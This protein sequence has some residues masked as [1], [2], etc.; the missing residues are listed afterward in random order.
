MFGIYDSL[1]EFENPKPVLDSEDLYGKAKKACD[2]IHQET[3][4]DRRKL[5]WAHR[6]L[7]AHGYNLVKPEEAERLMAE[8]EKKREEDR[9]A[10]KVVL[11][12]L[13][14]KFPTLGFM[15]RYF[16]ITI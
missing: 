16:G 7:R 5:K 13:E 2:T 4:T 11:K 14:D 10:K 3:K 1:Y 15:S 6:Y 12:A 8:Y 9:L